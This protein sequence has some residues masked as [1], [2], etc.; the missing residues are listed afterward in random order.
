MT[1]F[2]DSDILLDAV[3][4]REP[5]HDS[6]LKVLSLVDLENH[7]LCVSAHSLLNVYYFTRKLTNKSTA[8]KSI[9]LLEEKLHILPT[10][11]AAI[12]SALSTT[13]TDIED[14]VQHAIALA[15]HCDIIIT[16][17]LKDYKASQIP[18]MNAQQ[19]L[20]RRNT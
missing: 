17:N 20:K 12:R 14:A 2:I 5:Y 4:R 8:A 3:L 9:G 6:A 1:L 15:N 19:Y 16:R 7:S 18:V 11:S 13:F 10:N